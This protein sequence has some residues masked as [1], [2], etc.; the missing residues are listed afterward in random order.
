MGLARMQAP[1]D[2]QELHL[3]MPLPAHFPAKFFPAN[4]GQD[5][6]LA[7]CCEGFTIFPGAGEVH[8]ELI[9]W[10]EAPLPDLYAQERLLDRNFRKTPPFVGILHNVQLRELLHQPV[11]ELLSWN[12]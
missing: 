5:T 8:V 9:P 10:V 2:S 7:L 12:P 3:L 6:C 11:V 1:F 4:H